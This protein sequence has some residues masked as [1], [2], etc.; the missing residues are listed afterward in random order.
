MLRPWAQGRTRELQAGGFRPVLPGGVA[1]PRRAAP[2]A[3]ATHATR[4]KIGRNEPCPCGSGA[5]HKK[6]CLDAPSE[7][8]LERLLAHLGSAMTIEQLKAAIREAIPATSPTSP[9]DV[10]RQALRRAQ[11]PP[12][13]VEFDSDA[14][15]RLFLTHFK[16]LWNRLGTP[17][18]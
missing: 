3:P 10:L 17:Q 18:P 12:D 7:T 1:E 2:A 4:R 9:T 13:A 6:C 14:Q 5:K 15:S 16:A 11:G 8:V